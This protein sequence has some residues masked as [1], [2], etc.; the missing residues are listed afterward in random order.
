MLNE[1]APKYYTPQE[2]AEILKVHEKT[3]YKWIKE[4]KIRAITIGGVYRI[5]EEGMP[6]LERLPEH[7]PDNHKTSEA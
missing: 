1:V 5:P 3:I 4:G 2:A 6:R 7:L